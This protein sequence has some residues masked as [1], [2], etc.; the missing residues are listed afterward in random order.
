MPLPKIVLDYVT[1]DSQSRQRQLDV[2]AD[3]QLVF[4]H[5]GQPLV[6]GPIA[7]R[8]AFENGL[9]AA[10]A[11]A[12]NDTFLIHA[13]T[14]SGA[15]T[16]AADGGETLTTDS[17]GSDTAWLLGIANTAANFALRVASKARFR[18]VVNLVSV[19]ACQFFAGLN[20]NVTDPD[21]AGT[22]G[23]GA[24]FWF[25][26]AIAGG[27]TGLA[28]AT[29]VNFYAHQKVDGTDTYADTGIPVIANTD[30]ELRVDLDGDL[31]PTWRINGK[32]VRTGT[33][34]LTSGDTVKTFIAIEGASKAFDCRLVEVSRSVG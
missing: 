31:I 14:N 29:A 7:G 19:A 6:N 13:E 8:T 10:S 11:T 4:D 1:G 3:G 2:P 34:A 18:T 26:P 5:Q 23:D 27:A 16:V 17:A 12:G 9:T 30:Y 25:D 15:I 20:E 21:P 28:A 32:V 24:G 22:A 33:V